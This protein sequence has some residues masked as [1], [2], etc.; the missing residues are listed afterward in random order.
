[1]TIHPL[2]DRVDLMPSAPSA[3]P[4]YS[5]RFL[6]ALALSTVDVKWAGHILSEQSIPV[7]QVLDALDRGGWKIVPKERG[8]FGK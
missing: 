7:N 5:A 8:D 2:P 4:H 3:A 6:I 1:M